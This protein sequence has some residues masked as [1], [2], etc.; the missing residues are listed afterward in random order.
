MS[1]HLGRVP[2]GA[3]MDG[4]GVGGNWKVMVLGGGGEGMKKRIGVG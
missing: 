1:Q 2:V 4:M 3:R